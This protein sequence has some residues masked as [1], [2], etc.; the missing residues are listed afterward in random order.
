MRHVSFLPGPATPLAAAGCHLALMRMVLKYACLAAAGCSIWAGWAAPAFARTPNVLVLDR[1][2]HVHVHRAL[3]LQSEP[4]PRP[5]PRHEVVAHAARSRGPTVVAELKRMLAEG[6]L[7]QDSYDQRRAVYDDA[8][9]AVRRLHG[10]RR[11]E[12][13]DILGDLSAMAAAHQLTPTRL[14]ALFGT[15]AAN[16][17]WWTP[18]RCSATASA[19][20]SRL[21]AGVAVLPGHGLQI[22]WL[23]TFGKLNGLWGA[24]HQRRAAQLMLDEALRSPPSAP[25]GSPGS[26]CSTSTAA[27]RRG[28]AALAQGTGAAGARAHGRAGCRAGRTCSRSSPRALGIFTRRPP[29]GRARAADGGAP[30]P[31]VLRS[32]RTWDPQRLHPVARRAARL[33]AAVRQPA[34]AVAVE[35]TATRA[36][37]VE[38]PRF[39][40]GAWSLYSLG[41]VDEESDLHYHVLLR[42][43]LQHLCDRTRRSPCSAAP[44]RTSPATSAWRRCSSC[45]P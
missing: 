30:L 21:G 24:Q 45:G 29:A 42:D 3:S 7:T 31:A 20:A 13:A 40:T 17:R 27:A 10:T 15:L 19:S 9:R 43:F 12:L 2:G 44:P 38:V 26:T 23:G 32:S 4:G 11:L 35:A 1:H 39:D 22:Q 16:R 18:G 28:S 5:A 8:R 25:A 33:R 34:R 37:R 36:A 6:T 14:P 41:S